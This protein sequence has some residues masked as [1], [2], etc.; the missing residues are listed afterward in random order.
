MMTNPKRLSGVITL[1]RQ[2]QV[3]IPDS[4]PS[5]DVTITVEAPRFVDEAED[6]ES[7]IEGVNVLKAI[8]GSGWLGA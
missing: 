6:G 2:L 1:D 7:P 4:I 3:E 8:D 5:G